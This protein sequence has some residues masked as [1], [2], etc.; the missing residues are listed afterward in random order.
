LRS[1]RLV[2]SDC[3]GLQFEVGGRLHLRLN[4]NERPIANKY[5]EVKLKRALERG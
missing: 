5:R 4:T 2:E 1:A 3:L